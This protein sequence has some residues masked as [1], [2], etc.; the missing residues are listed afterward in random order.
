[1]AKKKRYLALDFGV[2]RGQAVLGSFSGAKLELECLHTFPVQSTNMLG[3]RYWDFPAMLIQAKSGVAAA[4]ARGRDLSSLG[5]ASWGVDFGLLDKT[6]HLLANPVHHLDP[7]T[8]EAVDKFHAVMPA[9]SV[10][11]KTGIKERREGTLYQLHAMAAANSPLLDKAVT[12]LLMADLLSYFFTGVPVQEYTLATT[13]GMYDAESRDWSRDIILAARIPPV[14]VP[15]IVAP[16]SVIGPVRDDVA[17]ECGIGEIPVVAPGCHSNACAVASVPASGD[18]WC[19]IISGNRNHV[20]VELSTPIINDAA[21][22]HEFSNVG[23]VDGTVRFIKSSAGFALAED[24]RAAWELED[25][26]PLVHNE[27]LAQAGLSEPLKRLVNPA[28]PRLQGPGSMPEKIAKYLE[29]TGQ[30]APQSRGD[31]IRL[32][33]DSL[34]LSQRRV[35]EELV[36]VTGRK[37]ATAHFVGYGVGSRLMGQLVAD[38]IGAQVKTGPVEAKAIGNLIMQAVALGDIGSLAEGREIVAKSFEIDSFEPTQERGQWD[39]A[40]GRFKKLG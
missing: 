16:G 38:A 29:E 23:G 28:S 40:F 1:M 7:R 14:M 27:L 8:L 31:F 33:L 35:A 32:C 4:A 26:K 9:R 20:G 30:P 22:A 5:V 12:M 21:Y 10:Y 6:G 37:Y 39:D 34:A 11:Q 15:E 24:C 17:A 25:Q 19:Y 36:E 18:D 2:Q 3:T 13:T